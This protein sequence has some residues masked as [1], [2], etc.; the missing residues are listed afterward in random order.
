M[1]DEEKLINLTYE[2][3]V[4]EKNKY[5]SN[6]VRRENDDY[7][8]I[9]A[10]NK[11]SDFKKFYEIFKKNHREYTDQLCKL[12]CTDTKYQIREHLLKSLQ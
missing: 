12:Y 10:P 4:F 5:P 1:N 2:Q 6:I 7:I 9:I 3:A 8:I 11:E